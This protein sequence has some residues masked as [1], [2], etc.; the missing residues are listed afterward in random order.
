MGSGLIEL[1]EAELRLVAGGATTARWP[2]SDH[3]PLS[4]SP[5]A[6]SS[7]PA[8]THRT[9]APPPRSL[10]WP[11]PL[12]VALPLSREANAN[13]AAFI[14]PPPRG[15][16]RRN[17][18]RHGRFI[19][20]VSGL[21]APSGRLSQT[22]ALGDAAGAAL[23]LVRDQLRITR[24][25]SLR[26]DLL[27]GWPSSGSSRRSWNSA[28]CSLSQFKALCKKRSSRCEPASG[29]AL[30][31]SPQRN[32]GV[33]PRNAKVRIAAYARAWNRPTQGP[34]HTRIPGGPADPA[35]AVP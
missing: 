1:T 34:A 30:V 9:R 28:F 2:P 31:H 13:R 12:P 29:E 4:Y 35:V 8:L 21:V 25:G 23:A 10:T 19:P 24:P 3:S 7:G 26:L 33:Y 14:R 22:G 32:C 18:T 5:A 15:A 16:S 20:L 11:L 27:S 17:C 6:A